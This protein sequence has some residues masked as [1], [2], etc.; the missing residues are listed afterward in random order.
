MFRLPTYIFDALK[1][2]CFVTIRT[3]SE[4]VFSAQM[5]DLVDLG[6]LTTKRV[7]RE[8]VEAG[9]IKTYETSISPKG[10]RALLDNIHPSDLIELIQ[11][12]AASG[13]SMLAI[14]L[15]AEVPKGFLPELMSSSSFSVRKVAIERLDELNGLERRTN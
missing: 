7:P 4:P 11:D 1:S 5:Q 2:F 12:G 6:Y 14:E 10:K 3:T 15:V 8:W 9:W 13:Y